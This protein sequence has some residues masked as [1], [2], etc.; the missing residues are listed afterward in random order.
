MFSLHT[1][2]YGVKEEEISTAQLS[3][4]VSSPCGEMDRLCTGRDTEDGESLHSTRPGEGFF[5]IL[6]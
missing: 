4:L 5:Y 6:G 3:L 1:Q 2:C